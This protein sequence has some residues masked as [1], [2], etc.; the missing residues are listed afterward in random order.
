MLKGY[1]KAAGCPSTC[2]QPIGEEAEVPSGYWQKL[3][4]C[5]L[6]PLNC[7]ISIYINKKS[8]IHCNLKTRRTPLLIIFLSHF[9][10]FILTQ[11]GC[12]SPFKLAEK[13][14]KEDFTLNVRQRDQ[15]SICRGV[16]YEF[17]RRFFAK[18]D[19][20]WELVT[21]YCMSKVLKPSNM[22]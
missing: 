4:D 21:L 8:K 2:Q 7:K 20:S 5:G 17:W 22:Y 15:E 1:R 9:T 3:G 13:I 14:H 16:H 18:R 10:T 19:Y 12:D 11:T 6:F